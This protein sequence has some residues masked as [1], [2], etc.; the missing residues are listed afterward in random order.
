MHRS[1]HCGPVRL[2]TTGPA[3][4]ALPHSGDVVLRAPRLHHTVAIVSESLRRHYAV[5]SLVGTLAGRASAWRRSELEA[6]YSR[7]TLMKALAR[8]EV[9]TLLPGVIAHRD[10]ARDPDVRM[11]AVSLWLPQGVITGQ[12]ALRAWGGS[13][14]PDTVDV[15]VPAST[16]RRAVPGVRLWRSSRKARV[17]TH[18][19]M[20]LTSPA[21]ASIHAWA[22]AQHHVRVGVMLDTIRERVA[23]VA[24]IEAEA[25]AHTRLPGRAELLALLELARGGVTSALEHRARTRVFTG[26]RWR[27]IEWQARLTVGG[28]RAVVDMLHRSS[29]VVIELDGARYHSDDRARRRDI[30]RDLLLAGAGYL[31]IRL[32]WEDV[33]RRPQWCRDRV[34]DAIRA[35]RE[36]RQ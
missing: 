22:R 34:T 5:E 13:L 7:R 27:D 30:E 26:P 33:T 19:G 12:A 20:P 16:A 14:T 21:L 8:G 18:E 32:T 23:S 24:L 29:R 17:F 2:S 36:R 10:H 35:R 11:R 28:R 9:L 1:A 31:T 15:L 4:H 6:R 25:V 3:R